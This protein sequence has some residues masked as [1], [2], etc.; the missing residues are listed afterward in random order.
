MKELATKKTAADIKTGKTGKTGKNVKPDLIIDN[1]TDKPARG[2]FI[3][4]IKKTADGCEASIEI[5]GNC[6]KLIVS[7]DITIKTVTRFK[8]IV[9]DLIDEGNINIVFEL[10]NTGYVDSSGLGFFIGTLKKLKEKHGA[11]HIAG[12]NDRVK[13]LFKLINLTNIFEIYDNTDD[14]VKF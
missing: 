6:A 4:E 14:A 3:T 13:G 9:N 11:L 1:R 12:L 7:G 10:S 8:K 2:N 5:I